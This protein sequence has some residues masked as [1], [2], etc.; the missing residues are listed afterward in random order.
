MAVISDKMI[1]AWQTRIKQEDFN[2]KAYLAMSNWL[3]LSGFPGAA[4]LWKKY[5]E[6]ERIHKEWAVNFLLDLNILPIEPSQEE[7]QTKFKGLPNIIAL[8]F[9]REMKTTEEVKELASLSLREGDIISFGLA[10]KYVNEQVEE[11]AKAQAHID[12]LEAFG[13]SG[14]ALRLLDNKMAGL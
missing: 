9:E 3:N 14:V 11:L 7:P 12:E 5:A 10:Q 6:D 2:V 13:D 4:A 1:A 8:T